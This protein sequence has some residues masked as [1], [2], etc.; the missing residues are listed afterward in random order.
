MESLNKSRN[1]SFLFIVFFI[2]ALYGFYRSYFGLFPTFGPHFTTLTHVHGLSITVW[3]L[4]LIVQPLLIRFR[5]HTWHRL[6]GKFSYFYVPILATLMLLT[7]RQGYLKG[8][9]KMPQTNL[10]AFQFVPVSA[11]VCFL[12]SYIMAI[13]KRNDWHTHKSYMIVHALFCLWAAFGRMDY[14]WLG[15]TDFH[16]AIAVSYLPSLVILFV[17]CIYELSHKKIN[18]AYMNALPFFVSA[19]LFYYYFSTSIIWQALAKIIFE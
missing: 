6:L 4:I 17:L 19:P 12:L 15:V 13:V 2:C 16:E 3:M 5:K 7:I 8:L 18:K 1:S 14:R 10:L 9:G 11:F